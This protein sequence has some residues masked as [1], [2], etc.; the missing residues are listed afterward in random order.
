MEIHHGARAFALTAEKYERARPSYPAQALDWIGEAVPLVRGDAVVDLGAG[1]GKL[2]RLLVE[3]GYDVLAV[4]PVDE[5]RAVLEQR[6]PQART[7]KGTAEDIP[8]PEGSARAVTVAQ[9]F[10]WFD[11]ER[12]PSEIARVL[13][14]DG[15]LVVVT[16]VRDK[17]DP[18]QAAL[19]ELMGRY[20]GA[21]PNQHWPDTWHDHPLF[22]PEYREFRHEHVVDAATFVERVASVSWI[23][24]L[25]AAEKARVLAEARALVADADGPIRMPYITEVFVCRRRR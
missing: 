14:P 12:A 18:L 19:E 8:A 16:N 3:R 2:T 10:H 21:Y 4:E 7:A 5:M 1:T 24:A 9:A 25:A 22:V 23:G 17:E 13:Q 11:P 20:R 15:A 6:V